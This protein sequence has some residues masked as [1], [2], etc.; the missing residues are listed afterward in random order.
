MRHDGVA[1]GELQDA[2]GVA[3]SALSYQRAT[4]S[5]SAT[6]FFGT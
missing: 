5:L 4:D 1:A 6:G 2:V 3:C